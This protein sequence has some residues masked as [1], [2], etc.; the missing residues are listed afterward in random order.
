LD[1]GQHGVC[2]ASRATLL[3]KCVVK[4]LDVLH[5]NA[6]QLVEV[7]QL[8]TGISEASYD[9]IESELTGKYCAKLKR[10]LCQAFECTLAVFK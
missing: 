4:L 1:V 7:V 5:G 9:F 10:A 6:G 2:I 3:A 8:D